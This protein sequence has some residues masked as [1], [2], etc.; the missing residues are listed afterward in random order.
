MYHFN[1][2]KVGSWVKFVHSWCSA[3]IAT[4]LFQ[5]IFVTSKRSSV[6]ASS[7]SQPWQWLPISMDSPALNI[8]NKWNHTTYGLLCWL[9]SLCLFSRFI[10]VV[11]YVRTL[12]FLLL[13][14]IPLYGY[15]KFCLFH[16]MFLWRDL[17][18]SQISYFWPNIMNGRES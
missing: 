8:S 18:L 7:Q 12:F 15:T 4:I 2:F 1:H 13:N 10:C 6:P 14:K 3:N 9:F 11:V 17:S 5:N 16:F